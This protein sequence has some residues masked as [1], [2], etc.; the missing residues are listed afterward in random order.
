MI[1]RLRGG[2]FWLV[3]LQSLETP[4]FSSWAQLV[5]FVVAVGMVV[6]WIWKFVREKREGAL[7]GDKRTERLIEQLQVTMA[8]QTLTLTA[9]NGTLA[10][11]T[12]KVGNLPT[13][14]DLL[15][16]AEENRH[17]IRN[18]VAEAQGTI[19]EAIQEGKP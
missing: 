3:I 14:V 13:K 9:L 11:L 4:P 6:S 15:K 12:E 18:M 2:G 7:P 1:P 16:A 8:A 10:V 17:A 5:I 19:V